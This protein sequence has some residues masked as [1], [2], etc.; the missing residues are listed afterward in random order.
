MPDID[1]V[2]VLDERTGDLSIC[3][4]LLAW[5]KRQ[6]RAVQTVT[7]GLSSCMQWRAEVSSDWENRMKVQ[8]HRLEMKEQYLRGDLL[9]GLS[10]GGPVS[11]A[12]KK[13]ICLREALLIYWPLC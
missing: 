2:M 9:I 11:V 12:L 8:Q 4:S 13:C 7:A 6:T 3:M 1:I 10:L 5:R